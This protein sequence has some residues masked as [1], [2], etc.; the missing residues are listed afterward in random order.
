MVFLES[1]LENVEAPSSDAQL[2]L[3]SPLLAFLAAVVGSSF[4]EDRFDPGDLTPMPTKLTRRVQ[5][6]TL[7]LNPEPEEIVR[8]LLQS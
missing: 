8:S 7:R 4:A 2:V 1:L 6:F 3:F 5:A